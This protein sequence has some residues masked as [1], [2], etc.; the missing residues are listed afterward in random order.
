[1]IASPSFDGAKFFVYEI[2][3]DCLIFYSN[4]RVM[5]KM[6]GAEEKWQRGMSMKSS[7][8]PVA[9][10]REK[11]LK[12]VKDLEKRLREETGEEIVLVA[13]KHETIAT[14]RGHM[15]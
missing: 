4:S 14:G 13:Y 1:M 15:G 7:S 12:Q 10:L 8:F 5:N 2:C 6:S 11:A 9:H 3:N